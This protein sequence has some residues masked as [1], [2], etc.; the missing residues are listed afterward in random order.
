M[1]KSFASLINIIRFLRDS[2]VK[3]SKKML[4][5]IPVAYLLFPF[6][7]VGDF[8]PI[9]GQL[10]DVA[11]F[12]LMWPFL[13]SILNKYNE[14]NPELNKEKKADPDAVDLNKNDYTVE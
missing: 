12:V 4:F 2:D 3:I 13:K 10:D 14:G 7:L 1:Q 9:M 6:D 8:F 11:V 5:L